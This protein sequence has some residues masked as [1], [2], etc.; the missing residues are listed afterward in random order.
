MAVTVIVFHPL[1]TGIVADHDV[2]PVAVPL[3]PREFLQ[4]TCATATLSTACP[5]RLTDRPVTMDDPMLIVGGVVSP[6]GGGGGATGFA[7][8]V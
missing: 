8:T 7:G 1:R 3:S 4:V 5:A 2:V 6:G